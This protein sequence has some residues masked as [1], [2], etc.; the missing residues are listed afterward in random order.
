M[1]AATGPISFLEKA[2]SVSRMSSCSLVKDSCNG[3][4]TD[5]RALS[6]LGGARDR[7]EPGGIKACGDRL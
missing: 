4:L 6:L 2:R 1:A 3:G 5:A 7:A